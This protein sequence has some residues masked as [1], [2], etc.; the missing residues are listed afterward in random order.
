[1]EPD[2]N[3][4]KLATTSMYR[5]RSSHWGMWLDSVKVTHLTLGMLSKKGWTTSSV[6]SSYRPLM[7]KVGT[8]MEWIWSR[9]LHSR[10]DPVMW[11]SDGPFLS[12][13]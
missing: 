4:R 9:M 3:L 12:R 6:A 5:S 7:S 1:M 10:R 2:H 8:E 13:G 11:N